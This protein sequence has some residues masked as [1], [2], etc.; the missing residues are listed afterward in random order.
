MF[1]AGKLMGFRRKHNDALL[2]F[3]LRHF[4]QDAGGKRTTINYFSTR[5]SAGAVSGTMN[6]GTMSG[7][8]GTAAGSA[9][10]AGS[11]QALADANG[12]GGLAEVSASATTVRTV[13]HGDGA[14]RPAPG[15]RED[16][17]AGVL[18]GFDG[19]SLDPQAAAEIEA[20]LL[21]LAA[22]Q[23]ALC[24]AVEA[25]GDVR[26]AAEVEDGTAPLVRLGHRDLPYHGPLQPGDALFD[27]EDVGW[28]GGE[29]HWVHA[30]GDIPEVY[31]AWIAA[32]EARGEVTPAV[33]L[34]PPAPAAVA[35]VK[36]RPP[37]KR[38]AGAR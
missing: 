37:R 6:G 32:A 14:A 20:A 30:G 35:E 16:A 11:T 17:A 24:D 9:A 5:A 26:V 23:R 34:V 4:G 18:E 8:A 27:I 31:D 36:K 1:V 38:K 28:P 3:C 25:G 10:L 33:P 21:A 15:A 29:S 22:R 7:G 2:I 19:V 13:I 12:A